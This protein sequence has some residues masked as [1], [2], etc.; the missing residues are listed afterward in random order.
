ML[1]SLIIEAVDRLGKGT[2]ISGLKNKLDYFNVIHYQKPELLDYFKEKAQQELNSKFGLADP[3][4]RTLTIKKYQERSFSDM[5]KMLS[6]PTI[7][8][9]MDRGHLGEN[10]YAHRYRNYSGEYVFDLE[11]K[12][13]TNDSDCF[14]NSTLLVLLITSSF[15]FIKDDGLSFDFSKKE[16]EQVD[17][18]KSFNRS[19]IK[20]KLMIDVHDGEG[21]FV[22]PEDILKAVIYAYNE[23]ENL[24][25]QTLHITWHRDKG[26]LFRDDL[27]IENKR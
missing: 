11:Q 17:F 2:L 9:L 15:E 14:S 16:E 7:K 5:F 23:L 18:I 8:F 10:V 3:D 6:H 4:I 24:S 13:R 21:K 12:L 1:K 27:L 25:Y 19:I 20:H 26:N 22:P